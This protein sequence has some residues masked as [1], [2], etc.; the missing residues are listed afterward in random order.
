MAKILN[1]DPFTYQ[2]EKDEFMSTL[3][4]FH[5]NRGTPIG[6][7]P[8]IGGREID[9]YLLYR[10]V[11]KFGGWRKITDEL[12]WEDFLL[13]FKIPRDCSNGTQALKFIY[14]RYLDAYEKVY[15]HGADPNHRD[16]EEETE[17][18]LRKK[19]C[20]PLYG[21]PLSYNYDQHRVSAH[22]RSVVGMST[23]LVKHSD[24]HKLEKALLSGLPNEVDFAINVCTLLSSESRK[25]LLLRKAQNLLQLLMA[26]IGIFSDDHGTYEE[27]YEREWRKLSNSNFIHFWLNTVN[28]ETIRGLVHTS[29][30]Y[31]RKELLGQEIL[32]LGQ[33]DGLHDREGQRVMQLAVIIR[34]LSFEEENMK[35]MSENDLVFRFLMLCVHSS[36]G[37]LRQLAL[38]S[39]GNI[40]EKFVLTTDDHSH[41][42]LQLLKHCLSSDDKYEVVRGLE[43]LSKLCLLDQNEDMLTDRL[44]E[45]LYADI[46]RL[47][48]VFDIQIIVYSLEALYQLSELGEH[49]TTKIAAVKHAVDLLVSL[50]TIEAQSYGPNS[51][52]GIKV[53]E[54]CPPPHLMQGASVDHGQTPV[55]P[56]PPGGHPVSQPLPPSHKA[57][58]QQM[59]TTG[60]DV[61]TTTYQ[62][63]QSTFE[64][65]DGFSLPHVHM[66]A[67]YLNFAK[68]F[69]LP[70]I[71]SS[72]AFISCV[73]VVYP[74]LEH[75]SIEKAEGVSEAGFKGICKRK[76]PLPFAIPSTGGAVPTTNQQHCAIYTATKPQ[77][78]TSSSNSKSAQNQP[79]IMSVGK[80]PQPKTQQALKQH[81]HQ[82]SPI[83]TPVLPQQ[84]GPPNMAN[85]QPVDPTSS[86]TRMI[87]N[88]LAK[89]LKVQQSSP[90]PIAPKQTTQPVQAMVDPTNPMHL[91][92]FT[93]QQSTNI[94]G[95]LQQAFVPVYQDAGA[96]TLTGN[97]Y[98]QS[99]IGQTIQI[100][101]V[102]PVMDGTQQIV[103]P[104]ATISSQPSLQQTGS[105]VSDKSKGASKNSASRNS[106]KSSRSSSPKG[107]SHKLKPSSSPSR[108][109]SPQNCDLD[110]CGEVERAKDVVKVGL[111][112][113]IERVE[114]NTLKQIQ[115]V[116]S[117]TPSIPT[118]L[119]TSSVV[120]PSAV[121]P[122]YSVVGST[123]TGLTGDIAAISALPSQTIAARNTAPTLH[124]QVHCATSSP[125]IST[126]PFRG[127]SIPNCSDS[128]SNACSITNPLNS[129]PQQSIT[130]SDTQ[131]F[132]P[133]ENTNTNSCENSSMVKE[134]PKMNYV[135]TQDETDAAVSSL[136]ITEEDTQHS[137]S[138]GSDADVPITTIVS[139]ADETAAAISAIEGMLEEEPE[140]EDDTPMD[141]DRVVDSMEETSA[142]EIS[143]PLGNK[144]TTGTLE[145]APESDESQDSKKE[146]I[147]VNGMLNSPEET[148][149]SPTEEQNH[150]GNGISESESEENFKSSKQAM[151]KLALEKLTKINGIDKHIGNGN[152]NH[153]EVDSSGKEEKME[154][155]EDSVNGE[156]IQGEIDQALSGILENGNS[157]DILEN[158]EPKETKCY[159]LAGE[160][161]TEDT[162]PMEEEEVLIE[163][164]MCLKPNTVVLDP[165]PPAV[166]E[167]KEMEADTKAVKEEDRGVDHNQTVNNGES[168]AEQQEENKLPM[169]ECVD[170]LKAAIESE[171][172]D[173]CVLNGDSNDS[174]LPGSIYP[175]EIQI[176]AA[177]IPIGNEM[178]ATAVGSNSINLIPNVFT[179]VQTVQTGLVVGTIVSVNNNL[180]T[181]ATVPL[182][183]TDNM[184]GKN[185]MCPERHVPTPEASRDG[186]LSCDSIAS[187]LTDSSDKHSITFQQ[188]ILSVQNFPTNVLGV[189]TMSTNKNQQYLTTVITT[190]PKQTSPRTRDKRAKKRSRNASSGSGDSR[191]SN[192]ST[193]IA[194]PMAPPPIVPDFMCEWHGCKQCFE[195][196]K[197][198][199]KHVL[200]THLKTDV[201]GYC[202]W[203]G[204]EKLQRKKW[205][206][207]THVQD[208]HC[209][210]NAL[211]SAAMR[212]KQSQQSGASAPTQ[213]VPALV[214]P[215]D[216][217][218]QAIRRF[219]PK[220]PYPEF[221]EARE[222]PVTKHIRLTAALILRNL[223]R[224][225]APG[226]S[227][228]KRYERRISFSAMSALESSNALANC[229]FEILHDH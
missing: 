136:L 156:V 46:V 44:E 150:I 88:L 65:K 116:N 195:N 67:E 86:E 175:G 89:K 198:V 104:Q 12:I 139:S 153:V 96:Y 80:S 187:T 133:E 216:A 209:S 15:F 126:I 193:T 55:L 225:S 90:V 165:P 162:A 49:T 112:A 120:P 160:S 9:L 221:T 124:S 208:H 123:N 92:T 56:V 8:V 68:K 134:K 214:Y 142:D 50:L 73:R 132:N 227:L 110:I 144:Q 42:V 29:H 109:S 141:D 170:I 224:Y 53:V 125:A 91:L 194:Q 87:K 151:D 76:T 10:Q 31:S 164:E 59:G 102:Q 57:A 168:T 37:S 155:S 83:Q 229:L 35:F 39:L 105:L 82:A 192:S 147:T 52:V 184:I 79:S 85:Q 218:W 158:G 128:L 219:S 20:L 69:S 173:E 190:T 121:M 207:V 40:A 64:L 38:D 174:L 30:G 28:D 63:L 213:T 152:V 108:P 71:L 97:Y 185:V 178:T 60:C 72:A 2:Q 183:I 61:E 27:V 180:L 203:E 199:F 84:T 138:N 197:H 6:K 135:C 75:Y 189:Q 3:K 181:T 182:T 226:R 107:S 205:S 167:P 188:P 166:K 201:E 223:A 204:C 119:V 154:V 114:N 1:K 34:N 143:A 202:R 163:N 25:S 58:Q 111:E 161:E 36:Y 94:Q 127:G 5:R 118:H 211:K 171:K 51:L 145:I 62:W 159:E 100:Q 115:S 26:H 54:Y 74:N 129:I 172:I 210:E 130:S 200:D 45:P 212:K 70:Q 113:R 81:L 117:S 101:G 206:L 41:L 21:I 177:N 78:Q 23:D 77:T 222:G 98:D 13:D 106:S 228:I 66:Y 196:F 47:M 4:Q 191:C 14:V 186:E 11:I 95:Q 16:D 215:T 18:P 131:N 32:N 17:G 22:G 99:N 33:E 24:F 103:I 217:A 157:S 146:E 93:T 176:S 48:N 148:I 122:G 43:I 7:S 140:E 137:L 169:D 19:A 179:N 220:P 149:P